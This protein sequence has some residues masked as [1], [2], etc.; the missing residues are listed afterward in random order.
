MRAKLTLKEREMVFGRLI[1]CYLGDLYVEEVR[2]PGVVG[3][4]PRLEKGQSFNY[5]SFCP[6]RTEFGVMKGHYEMFFDDG[7]SFEAEIAPFQL[8][9]PHA[10]N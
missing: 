10:I 3:Y 4:Q 5:T 6:L 8:V 9:I 7:K 2:G 1:S